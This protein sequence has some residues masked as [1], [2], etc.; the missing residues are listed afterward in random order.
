M[1]ERYKILYKGG[2]GEITE[3]KSRFIATV[4]PVE[5]EEEAAAFIAEMKKRYWD[6]SHNCSAFVIG[7]ENPLTRCSDDG[8]PAQTAGRPMLDVLL[9]AEVYN[10]CAVVTR[11]FGGTL[12]GTGGLVR[13][14]SKAVR[15]GLLNCVILEKC[16]ADRLRLST[17]YSGLGKLQYILSE[18]GIA[19]L[20]SQYGEAVE[21]TILAPAA[22]SSQIRK[23]ITEGTNGRCGIELQGQVYYGMDAGEIVLLGEG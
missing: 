20:D 5:T 18:A 13:A 7:E 16:L 8:E 3:K 1:K 17:D 23:K 2:E 15:E 12:L 22:Q 19:V 11:Y 21:M 6:A 9:G 10:V 4:R 14:Y